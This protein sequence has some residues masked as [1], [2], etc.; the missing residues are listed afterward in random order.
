MLFVVFL[1]L[2]FTLSIFTG[3]AK[4]KEPQYCICGRKHSHG[5]KTLERFYEVNSSSLDFSNCF[6]QVDNPNGMLCNTCNRAL[7]RYKIS[8]KTSTRVSKQNLTW[9][10]RI[11]EILLKQGQGIFFQ[12]LNL[13]IFKSTSCTW[14]AWTAKDTPW[15]STEASRHGHKWMPNRPG[16][17]A[18]GDN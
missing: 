12:Y 15:T 17:M 1:Q 2:F 5:K 16:R 8:R 18:W 11:F 13:Q 6:G 7:S 14:T 3:K 4:S 9:S 10:I